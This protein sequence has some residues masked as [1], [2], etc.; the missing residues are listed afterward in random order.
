MEANLLRQSKYLTSSEHIGIIDH[1]QTHSPRLRTVSPATRALRDILTLS[2]DFQEHLAR[3]L[4]V[5]P[6]DL[7]AMQHLIQQGP[8]GPSDLARRLGISPAAVTTVV[9][10]LEKVGHAHR[11]PHPDDRRSVVIVPEPQ[12]VARAME[13]LMPMIM[14][15]DGVLGDFDATEQ[16]AIT[17]Y[18]EKVVSVYRA[19]IPAASESE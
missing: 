1:V 16:E 7:D 14:G 10:R 6:T 11:E 3:E 5:N 12:S 4:T 9:D 8:L 19:S 17:R 13:T 18:L 15:I 2:E